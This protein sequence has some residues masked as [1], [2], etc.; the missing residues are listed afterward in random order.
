MSFC[1]NEGYLYSIEWSPTRPCVFACGSD[2]GN[3]LIY[4][5][6]QLGNDQVQVVHVSDKPVYG[7]AFNSKRPGHLATADGDGNVKIWML[8]HDLTKIDNAEME[9]LDNISEKPFK[10]NNN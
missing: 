8:S 1:P 2:K 5:L 3:L 9:K 10:N 7:V 4:D 6:T